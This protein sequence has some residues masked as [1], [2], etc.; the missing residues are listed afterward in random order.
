M[1]LL[2]SQNPDRSRLPQCERAPHWSGAAAQTRKPSLLLF[3]VTNRS[4][5]AP[6]AAGAQ[7]P[8][9]D[10]EAADDQRRHQTTGAL[11]AAEPKVMRRARG[12][13]K[14]QHRHLPHE[15]PKAASTAWQPVQFGVGGTQSSSP[16]A[17]GG[18]RCV[19]PGS[20]RPGAGTKVR[21]PTTPPA[22]ERPSPWKA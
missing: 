7:W 9:R 8:H 6:L 12:L 19:R 15:P 14:Y 21:T 1:M 4:H 17:S 3:D 16:G 5:L 18:M 10:G 20:C 2:Q 13:P 11:S 22:R